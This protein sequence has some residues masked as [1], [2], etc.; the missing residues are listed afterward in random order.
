MQIKQKA[1]EKQRWG[2]WATAFYMFLFIWLWLRRGNDINNEF[3]LEQ[4]RR[5]VSVSPMH[6]PELFLGVLYFTRSFL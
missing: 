1:N 4:G 3:Q 5:Q 2:F 6:A